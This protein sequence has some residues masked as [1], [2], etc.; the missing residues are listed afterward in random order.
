MAKPKIL[1]LTGDA[2]ESLKVMYPCQR[3]PEEGY[4]APIAAP[5][6]TKLRFVVHDFEPGYDT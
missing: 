2:A 3:L 1:I 4:D 5:T 6:K